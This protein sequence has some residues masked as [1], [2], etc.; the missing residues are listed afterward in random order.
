M[1]VIFGIAIMIYLASLLICLIIARVIYKDDWNKYPAGGSTEVVLTI[2]LS[3][4]PILNTLGAVLIL[5]IGL[6]NELKEKQN[7]RTNR[8]MP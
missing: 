6:I 8:K 5:G 4:V 2:I 7:E 1:E 3:M